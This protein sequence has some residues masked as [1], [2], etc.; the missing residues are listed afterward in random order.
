MTALCIG[1]EPIM[2]ALLK[3]AVEA[4]PDIDEVCGTVLKGR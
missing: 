1:D 2:L 4:S 3:E